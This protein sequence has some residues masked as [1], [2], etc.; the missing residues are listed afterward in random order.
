MKRI[1][2][3]EDD[4][5]SRTVLEDSL[6]KWSYQVLTAVNGTDAWEI[7][8]QDD[9]PAMAILDWMMP[10]MDGLEVCRRIRALKKEAQ[11]YLIILS[12]RSDKE[13]V[14][15]GLDVGADDYLSKPVN[16][17]ELRAR[18]DAGRRIVD[19]Q[20][21]LSSKVAEVWESKQLLERTFAALNDA[22]LIVNEHNLEIMDCN[23]AALKIFSCSQEEVRGQSLSLLHVEDQNLFRDFK[24]QLKQARLGKGSLFF[25]EYRM[26]RKN[27]TEFLTEQKLL[28]LDDESGRHIG[29]VNVISDITEKK[30]LEKKQKKQQEQLAQA[31]KMT[32]LGTLV[33]GVAHEINN[34]N[35]LIMLNAPLL[36]RMWKDSFPILERHYQQHGDLKPAG[37]PFEEVRGYATELF[38]G[39]QE[40]CKRI[41]RIVSELKEFARETPLNMR[42]E[43]NLNDVVHAA[44]TMLNK[45][46][47]RH[48]HRFAVDLDPDLPLI[49]GDFVK[50]EQVVV[51]LLIN[52]FQ[53]LADKNQGI[54]LKTRGDTFH[55]A[56]ILSIEDQGEGIPAEIMD[57][58]FDPFFTTRE[59]T[60]GT[61]LGLAIA[62]AVI[63]D[64]G[65]TIDFDS[66]PGRGTTVTV[67]FHGARP[68]SRQANP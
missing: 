35:N 19:L 49:Q 21:A 29:W 43:V 10:G 1:L 58:I 68:G 13:D 44:L 25:A 11:P 4:F 45:T 5:A 30:H 52:S 54:T 6:L 20:S 67:T 36:E 14:V 51:N 41:K 64:H 38:S 55:G 16:I 46:V 62:S 24:Q 34:P 27:G 66:S 31:A 61:G 57:R 12:A 40:G 63:Q 42:Q 65:G 23:P 39:V 37:I 8:R 22:I 32:A 48:T 59:K 15:Q 18:I 7:M 53:A 17:M 33:A 28:S 26:R 56:V 47:A 9:A 50:L 2:I 60:G 3:A